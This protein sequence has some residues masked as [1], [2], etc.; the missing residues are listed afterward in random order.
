MK[1][2]HVSFDKDSNEI[3]LHYDEFTESFLFES[4]GLIYQDKIYLLFRNIVL[5]IMDISAS[6]N[7]YTICYAIIQ[8]FQHQNFI[9]VYEGLRAKKCIE[10]LL[11]DIYTDCF[12]KC[13]KRPVEDK[14]YA[15][16]RDMH[17]WWRISTDNILLYVKSKHDAS[18]MS[19]QKIKVFAYTHELDNYEIKE[20][21]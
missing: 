5:G 14:Y 19:Y 2:H 16:S 12:L 1:I 17:L 9:K 8:S 6:A 20:V 3:T 13:F 21:V 7:E 18:K 4:K 15:M 11:Y 10:V